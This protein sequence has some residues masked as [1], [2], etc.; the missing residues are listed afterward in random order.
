[1]SGGYEKTYLNLAIKYDGTGWTQAGSLINRRG[2]HRSI[3]INNSI[4]HIGGRIFL[5][6][7]EPWRE[8]SKTR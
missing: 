7:N 8:T 2:A 4:M 5:G 6:S 1:M 3:V